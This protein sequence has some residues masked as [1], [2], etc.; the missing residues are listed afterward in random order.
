MV[1]L[2][3]GAVAVAAAAFLV[4][5]HL[6]G[7]G[8]SSVDAAATTPTPYASYSIGPEPTTVATD[9]P[10]AGLPVDPASSEDAGTG[11][12]EVQVVLTYAQF[13]SDTG[14]VQANGFVSGVIQDGGTCT[15][16]LRREG[17][18][19][20]VVTT[21]ASADATT[22][23]CGLLETGTGLASG[24]WDVELAYSS[25]TASGS[26]AVDEVVVP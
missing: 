6:T 22:T 15:L 16:T 1:L 17:Q 5:T 7:G 3:L 14:T 12:P 11:Q 10:A 13:Q 2:L 18:D 25:D 21:V 20:V 26:S 23:S 8:T 19:D 24:T 9:P 4:V